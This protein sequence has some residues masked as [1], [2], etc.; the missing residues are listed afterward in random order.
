MPPVLIRVNEKS[1]N[2]SSKLLLETEVD[3]SFRI[4]RQETDETDEV[5]VVECRSSQAGLDLKLIIASGDERE[6][7]RNFAEVLFRD[8][9]IELRNTSANQ[10]IFPGSAEPIN[11]NESRRL[12]IPIECTLVNRTIGFLWPV[13]HGRPSHFEPG[14][15]SIASK[16]AFRFFADH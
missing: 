7:S 15:R 11:P 16:S 14:F 6:Y 3:R 1:Q 9:K 5:G 2:L 4:G 13:R 8:D 10:S 12:P